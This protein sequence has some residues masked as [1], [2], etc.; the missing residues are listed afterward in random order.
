MMSMAYLQFANDIVRLSC[1]CSSS[2]ILSSNASE[3]LFHA[4]ASAMADSKLVRGLFRSV[5][6]GTVHFSA[7]VA[8]VGFA[9]AGRVA[10]LKTLKNGKGGSQRGTVRVV[11]HKLCT[12]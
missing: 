6:R 10:C 9:I 8:V 3:Y 4:A 7:F 5:R 2:A 1:S 11:R 12:P